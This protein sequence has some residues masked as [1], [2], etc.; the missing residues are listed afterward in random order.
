MQTMVYSSR[1]FTPEQIASALSLL[2]IIP[3]SKDVSSAF[4]RW[5]ETVDHNKFKCWLRDVFYS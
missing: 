4:E 2:E 5:I 3:N 1:N